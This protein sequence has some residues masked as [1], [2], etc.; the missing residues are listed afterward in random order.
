MVF[1]EHEIL[2]NGKII[3]LKHG[4]QNNNVWITSVQKEKTKIKLK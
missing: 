2:N 1:L 4:W 3:L